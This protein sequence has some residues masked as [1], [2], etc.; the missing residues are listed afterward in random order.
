MTI[1]AENRLHF[2][3]PIFEAELP[4][5]MARREAVRDLLL[6]LRQADG[7]ITRS[8][9][10]GWHSQDNLHQSEEQ[11]LQWLTEQIYQL[12]SQLIRHAEK[13]GPESPVYLS[14]LWANINDFGAWNAP[15]AHL[16]CE[17]SGCLYVDVNEAPEE[18]SNGI[19]PGDLMFFDPVPVGNPYRNATTVSYT[20][21]NGTL[22]LFPG[23]LLHMVAPHYQQDP[24]ISLAFNFR[25]GDVINQIAR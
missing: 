16:P 3:V 13:K 22:F 10:R 20:P 17:W 4:G 6:Q 11:L 21:R 23:Y 7:G 2:G 9:Q 19:A 14:S 25:L 15:H 1:R 5:F 8:N 24:R 12:G 18:K